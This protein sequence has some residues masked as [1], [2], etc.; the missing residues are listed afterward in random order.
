MLFGGGWWLDR[1]QFNSVIPMS[2]KM[3]PYSRMHPGR[4]SLRKGFSDWLLHH[5]EDG[6]LRRWERRW[7]FA[8][9]IK[10][11]IS[12]RQIFL[13]SGEVLD[14]FTWRVGMGGSCITE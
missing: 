3:G 11:L 4:T 12:I 5:W 1:K 10:K 6:F 7:L 2:R 8:T 14:V 13:T 9:N